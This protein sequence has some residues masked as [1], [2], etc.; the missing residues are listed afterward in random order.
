MSAAVSLGEEFFNAI[1]KSVVYLVGRVH[2]TSFP[3]CVLC[4]VCHWVHYG[5]HVGHHVPVEAAPTMLH[6]GGD[7]NHPTVC[8]VALHFI[9]DELPLY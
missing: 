4:L 9:F 2:K 8:D 5:Y 1:K 6:D 7:C 3:C